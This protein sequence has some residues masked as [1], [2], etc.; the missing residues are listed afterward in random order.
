MGHKP[1]PADILIALS[2]AESQVPTQVLAYDVPIQHFHADAA[3][4]QFSMH[5]VA[6]RCLAGTAQPCDPDNDSLALTVACSGCG[7][8]AYRGRV[9]CERIG[10]DAWPM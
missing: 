5:R 3:S 10:N 2:L 8:C 6:N 9:F 1:N 4:Q 7:E